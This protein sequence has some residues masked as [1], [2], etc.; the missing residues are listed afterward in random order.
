[1]ES[2]QAD[3]P[4]EWSTDIFS[5]IAGAAIATLTLTM[6]LYMTAYYSSIPKIPLS[7]QISQPSLITNNPRS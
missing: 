4:P 7:S 2:S 1:M 3:E 6:P 5:R